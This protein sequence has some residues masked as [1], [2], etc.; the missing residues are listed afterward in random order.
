M[1]Q[2][3]ERA[4]RR[5]YLLGILFGVVGL[6]A[7][8]EL[9]GYFGFTV[10]IDADGFFAPTL[11]SALVQSTKEGMP[12]ERAGMVAGDRILEVEGVAVAGARASDMAELMR[13]KPGETLVLRIMR[14]DGEVYKVRLVA[15]AQKS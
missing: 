3:T 14:T 1:S 12:A 7:A 10:K 9:K 13:K 4:A 6:V 11:K 15:V 8:Q 5:S 2:R